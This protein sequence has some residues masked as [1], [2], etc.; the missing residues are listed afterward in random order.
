MA[1]IIVRVIHMKE[2][3]SERPSARFLSVIRKETSI[4][5]PTLNQAGREKKNVFIVDTVTSRLTPPKKK[6]DQKER[7]RRDAF[8]RKTLEIDSASHPFD[9]HS[10]RAS[11]LM[12]TPPW[13]SARTMQ[14]NDNKDYCI[15]NNVH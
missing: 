9:F 4:M 5:E 3:L 15:R 2:V 12:R 10:L 1:V 6:R 7:K 13:S 11:T 14:M 8:S